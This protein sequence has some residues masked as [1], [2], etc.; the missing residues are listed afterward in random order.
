MIACAGFYRFVGGDP[1][2]GWIIPH[3]LGFSLD[4]MSFGDWLLAYRD[5]HARMSLTTVTVPHEGAWLRAAAHEMAG[6]AAGA[7]AIDG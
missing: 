5:M 7:P 3:L 6:A 4:G 2:G 1:P